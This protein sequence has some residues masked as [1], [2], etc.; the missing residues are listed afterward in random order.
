MHEGFA[1]FWVK[2]WVGDGLWEWRR[3][4]THLP[5]LSYDQHTEFSNVCLKL[6]GESAG[7]NCR[8]QFSWLLTCG[9]HVGLPVPHCHIVMAMFVCLSLTLTLS[10][11]SAE[12]A[13]VSNDATVSRIVSANV[14]RWLCLNVLQWRCCR[15][16]T[17]LKNSTYLMV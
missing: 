3:H 11:H 5:L 1:G 15:P 14:L 6:V 12:G 16:R 4:E 13:A 9:T 8:K 10:L 7:W 2:N 17:L